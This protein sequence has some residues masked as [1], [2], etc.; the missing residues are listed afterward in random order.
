MTAWPSAL[1][2]LIAGS[3]RA[4]ERRRRREPAFQARIDQD[5]ARL[6]DELDELGVNVADPEELR[7]G[8]AFV[9]VFQRRIDGCASLARNVMAPRISRA[10]RNGIVAELLPLLPAEARR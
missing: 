3:T 4:V 2:E 9:V 7:I 10:A 5:A 6:R 1:L 8:L